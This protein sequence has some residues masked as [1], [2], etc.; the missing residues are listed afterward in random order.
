MRIKMHIKQMKITKKRKKNAHEY[1][2][3]PQNRAWSAH[4]ELMKT[5]LTQKSKSQKK[6]MVFLIL[7]QCQVEVQ[8]VKIIK[9]IYCMY[10]LMY[11][12]TID[13]SNNEE[14]N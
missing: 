4:N 14:V 1:Y 6:C 8:P 2:Q 3:H 7:V 5:C 13:S 10:V 9:Y 12:A 11:M